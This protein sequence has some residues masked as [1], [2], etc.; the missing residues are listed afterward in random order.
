MTQKPATIV[1]III[2]VVLSFVGVFMTLAGVPL[3]GFWGLTIPT[4]T[5]MGDMS[6][7]ITAFGEMQSIVMGVKMSIP[8]GPLNMLPGIMIVAGAGLSFLGIRI[9][10]LGIVGG[11]LALSGP[12]IFIILAVANQL[13]FVNSMF[14]GGVVHLLTVLPD[15]YGLLAPGSNVL[16]GTFAGPYGFDAFYSIGISLFLPLVGGLLATIGSGVGKWE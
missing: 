2:G 5:P 14:P 8:G 6:Y 4:G 7:T 9:K 1:L 3:L 10:A 15:T 12:V 11:L 13:T 16:V